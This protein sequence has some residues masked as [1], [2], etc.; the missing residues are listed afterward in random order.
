[1]VSNKTPEHNDP[2]ADDLRDKISNTDK[3]YESVNDDLVEEALK[4]VKK[5]I[6]MGADLN[7]IAILCATNGDGEVIREK[8]IEE[9]IE[10]VTET[11]T[12]LINQRSVKAIIEYLEK[13][14]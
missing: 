1:M 13:Q 7:E 10:V 8:L 12:K 5:L 6:E 11:T 3:L 2:D 9:N 14:K 4:Q